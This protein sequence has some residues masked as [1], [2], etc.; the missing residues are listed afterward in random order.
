MEDVV[1]SDPNLVFGSYLLPVMLVCSAMGYYTD[2]QDDLRRMDNGSY[3]HSFLKH[4]FLEYILF[5]A[6]V[7]PMIVFHNYFEFGIVLLLI[8][9]RAILQVYN[10]KWGTII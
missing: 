2:F 1:I 7:I 10:K 6:L 3:S 5:F 8:P 4:F 9:K